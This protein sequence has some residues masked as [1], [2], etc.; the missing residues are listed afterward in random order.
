MAAAS[1][2]AKTTWI[3]FFHTNDVYEIEPLH[4]ING[5]G[6]L[7]TLLKRERSKATVNPATDE[8]V[9]ALGVVYAG[10]CK[11]LGLA[12]AATVSCAVLRCL[13]LGMAFELEDMYLTLQVS[14]P[15]FGLGQ[16]CLGFG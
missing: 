7:M 10:R 8:R 4:D 15:L 11:V 6:P 14:Y 5:S 12:D 9:G 3:N 1:I 2:S 16:L 13:G